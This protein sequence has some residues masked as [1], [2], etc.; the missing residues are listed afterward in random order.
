MATLPTDFRFGPA[1]FSA[2]NGFI[3]TDFEDR[4]L[5]EARF[6]DAQS[7]AYSY[8]EKQRIRGREIRL[9][10]VVRGDTDNES[11]RLR[12]DAQL[13]RLLNSEDYLSVFASPNE[14]RIR[15][16]VTRMVN[17]RYVKGSGMT[18]ARWSMTFRS[19]SP[20]WESAT[21]SSESWTVTTADSS[22]SFVTSNLGSFAVRPLVKIEN[23]TGAAIS[24][25][26]FVLT[27][28]SGIKQFAIHGVDIADGA[29]LWLDMARGRVGQP[30]FDASHVSLV[31][32]EPLE[33]PALSA[34]TFQLRTDLASFGGSG[35]RISVEWHNQFI[36]P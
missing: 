6:A 28:T 9:Q 22:H 10:G 2:A 12:M 15:C 8:F 18:V 32:G 21:A 16:A 17:P 33:I 11:L 27:E 3:I 24:N 1:Q 23:L 31:E 13:T 4:A 35:L 30:G 26:S 14:R 19:T 25:R 20:S 7:G 36:S 34:P 5:V 29:I